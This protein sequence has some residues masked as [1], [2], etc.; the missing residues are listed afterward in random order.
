LTVR[1]GAPALW[2]AGALL[3]ATGVALGAFG[4]HTL[5]GQLPLAM[6][7]VFETAVR[8]QM[9]HAP[10]ILVAALAQSRRPA[11]WWRLSGWLWVGG[12]VI[13]SGSLYLMVATGWRWL[14]ALT[15][16][17]GVLLIGG[18]CAA[19]YAGWLHLS[20]EVEGSRR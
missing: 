6:L 4:T 8:Y 7:G 1:S 16:L 15:P 3:G 12:I 13:F 20:G 17:G 9:L 11:G 5:R 18:W 10:A 2:L 14:G 19:G